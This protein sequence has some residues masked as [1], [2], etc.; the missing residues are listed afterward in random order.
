MSQVWKFTETEFF[1]LWKDAT[2]DIL[3]G[4][5]SFRSES[6]SMTEFEDEIRSTRERLSHT[7][8]R[9]TREIFEAIANPDL[10]VLVTGWNEKV[11]LDPAA[12]IRVLASRKSIKGYSITQLPGD[13]FWQSSGYI[14]TECDPLRLADEAVRAL[15]D[16]QV[17]QQRDFEL[18]NHAD[19]DYGYGGSSVQDTFTESR[20]GRSHRFLQEAASRAGRIRVIQGRS[21]FG[22]RGC[23]QHELRWRDLDGDGRYVIT[24]EKPPAVRAVDAKRLT[25]LINTRIAAVIRSIKEERE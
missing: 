5:F 22:P 25:A 18:T 12:Q 8:N 3:P 2:N 7:M 19:Y 21:V 4:P 9:A 20:E 1:V 13:S 6:E 10:Y 16:T 24:D 17:G 14:V 15:P 23:A 11:A